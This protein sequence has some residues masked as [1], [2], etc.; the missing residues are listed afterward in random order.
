MNYTCIGL[1]N[2]FISLNLVDFYMNVTVALKSS[3]R[4]SLSGSLSLVVCVL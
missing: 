1:Y 3:V 2:V 4:V